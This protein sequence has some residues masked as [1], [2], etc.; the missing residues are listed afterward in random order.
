M[1]EVK[2]VV[3]SF[4]QLS[5]TTLRARQQPLERQREVLGGVAAVA[6]VRMDVRDLARHAARPARRRSPP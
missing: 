1:C 5:D 3:P 2:S 4:G 6:V